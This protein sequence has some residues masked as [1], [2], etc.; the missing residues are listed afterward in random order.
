MTKQKLFI[1]LL[2]VSLFSSPSVFAWHSK[3]DWQ[4]KKAARHYLPSV[5]WQLYKAQLIQESSLNSNAISPVG[6]EGIAQFMPG[7]W[8]EVSRQIGVI[9]SPY[10]AEI[11]I[12]AGAYYMARLRRIWKWPRSEEDRHNLAMACYNAGCG[13]ILKAQQLCGN[14]SRYEPIMACLPAVTGKHADETLGYAPRIRRIFERL[15]YE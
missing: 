15:L 4:I 2:V 3:Y 11:A 9:G 5:P 10:D 12:P 13:N 6:A 14:P 8:E 1:W 7:T